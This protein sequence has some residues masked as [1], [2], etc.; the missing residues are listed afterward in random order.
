[1]NRTAVIAI[2]MIELA[3]LGV[4]PLGP[5]RRARPTT[6]PRPSVTWRQDWPASEPQ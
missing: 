4:G 3:G 5:R 2:V 1:M 6:R